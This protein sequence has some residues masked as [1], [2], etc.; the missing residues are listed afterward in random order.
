MNERNT[1]AHRII[2]FL[3]RKCVTEERIVLQIILTKLNALCVRCK[4]LNRLVPS[5]YLRAF[6]GTRIGY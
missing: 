3:L 5:R 6:W 1:A 4:G 2:V